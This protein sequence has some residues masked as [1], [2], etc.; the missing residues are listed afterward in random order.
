MRT[1]SNGASRWRGSALELMAVEQDDEADTLQA[2]EAFLREQLA[3]RAVPTKVLQAAAK[4][5]GHQWRTI[6]RAE[7][8]LEIAATK[9]GFQGAWAWRLPDPKAASA[10]TQDR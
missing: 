3:N 5:H 4:A 9:E 2:A 10:D 7:K 1:G 8:N 6:G